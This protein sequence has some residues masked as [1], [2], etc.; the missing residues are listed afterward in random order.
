M[1]SFGTVEEVKEKAAA[2]EEGLG[3]AKE[4]PA[5]VEPS[6]KPEE[7]PEPRV[8]SE[9]EK[10]VEDAEVGGAEE[11]AAVAAGGGA[12][13]DKVAGGG[14]VPEDAGK[15]GKMVDGAETGAEEDEVDSETK[16]LC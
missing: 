4:K 9:K 6:E 11:V 14:A 3:A 1:T 16:C 5:E 10:P 12:V 7:L 2:S 8:G 15:D 13:K